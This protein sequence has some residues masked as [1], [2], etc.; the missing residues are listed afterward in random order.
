MCIT[1][2]LDKQHRWV[3]GIKTYSGYMYL[4]QDQDGFN[5]NNLTKNFFSETRG[6]VVLYITYY[7]G[8]II[9]YS[10]DDPRLA[11]TYFLVRLAMVTNSFT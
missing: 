3:E 4:G 5:G 2:A 1:K 11:L 10:N 9:I 8:S 7:L 6:P